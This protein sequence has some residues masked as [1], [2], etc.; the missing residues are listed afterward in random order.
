[1]QI[2]CFFSKLHM[3]NCWIPWYP[4][5]IPFEMYW[6]TFK[7]LLA[8]LLV[9]EW[10]N[11]NCIQ[12]HYSIV[13]QRTKLV[14][15]IRSFINI[16]SPSQTFNFSLYRLFLAYKNVASIALLWYWYRLPGCHSVHCAPLPMLYNCQDIPVLNVGFSQSSLTDLS[17]KKC[18]LMKFWVNGGFVRKR[19][20]RN[21]SKS[22]QQAER[23]KYPDF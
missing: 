5:W 10:L 9:A 3:L 16:N 17:T 20:Q 11:V 23:L 12:W 22:M 4:S 19:L 2:S 21:C 15:L 7:W 8:L 18:L 6:I 13:S 1:M 14:I